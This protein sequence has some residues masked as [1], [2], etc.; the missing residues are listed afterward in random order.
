MRGAAAQARRSA[1]SPRP[2]QPRVPAPVHWIPPALAD[3]TTRPRRLPAVIRKRTPGTKILPLQGAK[4]TAQKG[5]AGEREGKQAH[6][7]RNKK[8]EQSFA[9]TGRRIQEPRQRLAPAR[10]EPSELVLAHGEETHQL[11]GSEGRSSSGREP[12]AR[13][14]AYIAL[15]LSHQNLS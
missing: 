15:S 13:T 9:P 2:S 14:I 4:P 6:P 1:K 3:G 10:E 11:L 8:T 7:K 5:F 12:L